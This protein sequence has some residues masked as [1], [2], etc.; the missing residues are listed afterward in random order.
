MRQ[1][2]NSKAQASIEFLTMVGLSITIFLVFFSL[3]TSQGKSA[4][5]AELQMDLQAIC[6]DFATAANLAYT[7]GNGFVTFATFPELVRTQNYSISIS[8]R[9]AYVSSGSSENS[10]VVFCRLL[11]DNINY[12]T[13]N[14]GT[15]SF[16][17]NNG[18]LE[19]I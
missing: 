13:I 6:N 3:S 1:K 7:G 10:K 9:T 8:G 4:R 2:T 17:N 15:L 11:T 16:K 12:S 18:T 5:G 14:K 19:I